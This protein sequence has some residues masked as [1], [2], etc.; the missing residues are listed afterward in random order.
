MQSW[1]VTTDLHGARRQRGQHVVRRVKEVGLL[2]PEIARHGEL[3]ADR[4]TGRRF[5]HRLEPGAQLGQDLQVPRT[6]QHDVL[7]G[8]VHSRQ[9]P[10]EAA[11]VGADA[12]KTDRSYGSS[13]LSLK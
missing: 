13:P 9:L 8:L 7:G 10:Q 5:R 3:L 4:V 6:A 11:N 2:A 1:I 12:V